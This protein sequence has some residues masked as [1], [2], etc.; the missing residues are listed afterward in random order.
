MH[1]PILG[2]QI[3]PAAHHHLPCPDGAMCVHHRTWSARRARGIDDIAQ[4]VGVSHM[5]GGRG[6]IAHGPELGQI[7]GGV[8]RRAGH[9]GIAQDRLGREGGDDRGNL[10]LCQCGGGGDRHQAC[11]QRAQIGQREIH[12]IAKAHQHDVPRAQPHAQQPRRGA[13]HG[14]LKLVETPRLNAIGPDN[15]KRRL[16]DQIGGAAQNM[17][18]KIERGGA[19]R[20]A[21]GRRDG[22]H[23][24]SLPR[25]QQRCKRSGAAL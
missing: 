13:A 25:A 22:Q 18:G 5:P 7:H 8:I 6:Q 23:A 14:G 4:P 16:V 17:G 19:R 9:G 3:I 11:G 15:G 12:S 24:Q 10:R 1:D 2:L 20:K 21:G